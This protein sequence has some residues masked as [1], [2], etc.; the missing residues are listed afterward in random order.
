MALEEIPRRPDAV[1][2]HDPVEVIDLVLKSYGLEAEAAQVDGAP[3][4]IEPL[5]SDLLCAFHIRQEVGEA[6]AAFA[7]D[8]PLA[9]FTDH[10]V[11][12][13]D[14]PMR[15]ARP[16]RGRDVHD[17]RPHEAADLR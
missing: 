17:E 7:A 10:G 3:R 8:L 12:D 14:E 13:A 6:E 16:R 4:G 5:D 2:E 1:E 15:L 9:G 11:R